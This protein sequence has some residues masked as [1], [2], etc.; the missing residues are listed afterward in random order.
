MVKLLG[1]ETSR[2]HQILFNKA[3]ARKRCRISKRGNA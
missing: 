1:Q 3:I 2:N